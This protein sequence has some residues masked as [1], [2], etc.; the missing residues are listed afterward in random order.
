VEFTPLGSLPAFCFLPSVEVPAV[1]GMHPGRPCVLPKHCKSSFGGSEINSWNSSDRVPLAQA[2]QVYSA[3]HS[4]TPPVSRPG[5]APHC[6]TEHGEHL[7]LRVPQCRANRQPRLFTA[8]S[9]S[10]GARG[11]CRDTAQGNPG[12]GAAVL[13]VYQAKRRSWRS[14]VRSK[15]VQATEGR[16]SRLL[17]GIV[18]GIG[19]D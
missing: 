7:A 4:R 11:S 10:P 3:L 1:A 19:F 18:I 13:R 15:P 16:G 5:P 12:R 6:A 9:S 17:L 14:T 8:R 2:R